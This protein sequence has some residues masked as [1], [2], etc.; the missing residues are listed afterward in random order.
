[1]NAEQIKH[2]VAGCIAVAAVLSPYPGSCLG[3]TCIIFLMYA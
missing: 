3:A 2:I 1:M